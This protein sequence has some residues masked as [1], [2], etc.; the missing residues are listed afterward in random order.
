MNLFHLSSDPVEAAQLN[1]DIHVVKICLEA[2]QLLAN[3]FSPNQLQSAP[4]T[5]SGSVRKYSH[6]HHPISKY[7]KE[8]MGNY[9]WALRH[10]IALCEEFEFRFG[11]KHFCEGFIRWAAQNKPE[12]VKDG[13]FTE[14]PQCFKQ[15]PSCYVAGNPVQGYRNY[16][17]TAK[18]SFDMRGK[19][20][21]ATWTGRTKPD[22]MI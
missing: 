9:E 10:G 20:V 16:Y 14:F 12:L 17:K 22:F 6:V 2:C 1:Q 5:Q 15:F 13:P 11:K 21:E 8:S 3:C 7:V 4:L 19:I 18:K